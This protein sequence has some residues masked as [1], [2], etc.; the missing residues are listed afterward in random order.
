MAFD[1]FEHYTAHADIKRQKPD[2]AICFSQ[3]APFDRTVEYYADSVTSF[4]Q[5][6]SVDDDVPIRVLIE[7]FSTHNTPAEFHNQLRPREP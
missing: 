6:Y 3:N 1:A 2:S 5:T 7:E 4:Y